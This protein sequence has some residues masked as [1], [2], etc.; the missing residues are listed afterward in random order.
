MERRWIG[1]NCPKSVKVMVQ[2]D[3]E[4][5]LPSSC[6]R[7]YRLCVFIS[8][9]FDGIAGQCRCF[10]V[11][12]THICRSFTTWTNMAIVCH[13]VVARHSVLHAAVL[14]VLK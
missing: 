13:V 4:N 7:D 2:M 5:K 9:G 1:L 8:A 10:P 11:A 6:N 14:D 3:V 12:S